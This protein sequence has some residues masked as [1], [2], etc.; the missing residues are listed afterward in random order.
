MNISDMAAD[1]SF[2]LFQE[3]GNLLSL[4]TVRLNPNQ[5]WLGFVTDMFDTDTALSA[6]YMKI[7]SDGEKPISGIYVI[8]T[9]DNLRIMGDQMQMQK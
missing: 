8:G 1:V 3:D 9:K 5:R 6:R 7:E 2:S 4:K